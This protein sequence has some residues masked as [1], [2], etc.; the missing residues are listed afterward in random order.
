MWCKFTD[1]SV[2]CGA[3]IL[4]GQFNVVQ[5]YLHV[6]SMWCKCTC[7]SVQCGA[8]ILICQYN[9]VQVY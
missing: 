7:M 8:S 5:V 2:Q 1:R 4:M 9:V 6:S 3:N